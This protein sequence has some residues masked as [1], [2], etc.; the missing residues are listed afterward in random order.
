[1]SLL[2]PIFEKRDLSPANPKAYNSSLWNLYG[3][4]SK[5]G[6]VVT[7]HNA[8]SFSAVWACVKILSD[9][10]A[11]LPLKLYEK[12]QN[13]GKTE[14]DNRTV[15]RLFKFPNEEMSG[16]RLFHVLIG[17]ITTWGN[18]YVYVLRDR[19]GRPVELWP[20]RP[21]KIDIQRDKDTNELFYIYTS[22]T[23]GQIYL[24][25][26]QMWH[27]PGFGFDGIKGYSV[28][29][30]AREAIGLG[31]AAEE[32]G[33]RYFGEGSHPSM[34]IKHPGKL[35]PDAHQSLKEDIRDKYTKLRR[36]HIPMLLEEG[37][38]AITDLGMPHDDA[39]FLETRYFQLVEI[40]RFFRVPP[41]LVQ[42]LSRSTF[43]NIEHQ[44][45]DFAMHS[46]RPWCV[47]LEK[48]MGNY[49]LG[50]LDRQNL[51]FEYKLEGLLRGD[52]KSRYE[53]YQTAIQ[54][55][56]MSPN[57]ARALENLNPDPD[58]D[59]FMAPMNF[60]PVDQ[61]LEEPEPIQIPVEKPKELPAPPEEE[62]KGF[63][64]FMRQRYTK[65][66]YRSAENRN[67]IA[68]TFKPV[69]AEAARAVISK[70][71]R[72]IGRAV[73]RYLSERAVDDFD[74][75]I[76]EFYKDMPEYIRMKFRPVL[77]SFAEAIQLEAAREIGAEEGVTKAL[78]K[79]ID[80]YLEAYSERHINQSI[81]ELRNIIQ[82][83]TPEE[84][85]GIVNNKMNHWTENRQT[86][87]AEHETARGNNA[88]TRAVWMSAG[89]TSL[90]W[91]AMGAKPCPYCSELDG[92]TVGIT[93]AFL[94]EGDFQPQGQEPMTM[95]TPHFH[96]PLHV[97]CECGISVG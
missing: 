86:I 53:A 97:G 50:P 56:W 70:E 8:M 87:I 58:L 94:T 14:I 78:Q 77:Q 52:T 11:S 71:V 15:L 31:M 29:A 66:K 10:I 64:E 84:L 69:F 24:D 48:E 34:I 95:R 79:F 85:A 92:R 3:T 47:L 80:A 17:H 25:R 12:A 82:S 1:M 5:T 7:E 91:I 18:W 36:A 44:S 40:C 75:W 65:I 33:A 93:S 60:K 59:F 35:S 76:D 90:I 6:L 19:V 37:M 81:R 73:T 72:A 22:D 26:S 9:T 88:I 13:G 46:I 67:K 63:F 83:S 42:D 96:P 61:F 39:Q 45:I 68:N 16:F 23:A 57:E 89:I 27:V 2:S 55:T 51:F 62:Q 32:F 49:W 74:S 28:I 41:H 4:Q 30:Q 43:S 38:D 21:D 20:L 54:S